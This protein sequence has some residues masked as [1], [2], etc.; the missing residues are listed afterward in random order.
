MMND[1]DQLVELSIFEHEF[2]ARLL[3]ER[4][5]END[6]DADIFALAGEQLGL[7]SAAT[8]PHNGAQVRVRAGD[9]D[10]A[11]KI[12]EEFNAESRDADVPESG[13]GED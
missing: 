7:L 10:R 3:I 11:V 2:I 8:A 5:A 12:L 4:L 6:I 9:Y 13:D 1:P